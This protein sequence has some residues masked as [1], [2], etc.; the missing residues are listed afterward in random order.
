VSRYV[1]T[2]RFEVE[3]EDREDAMNKVTLLFNIGF[4]TLVADK[5][6]RVQLDKKRGQ[7]KEEMG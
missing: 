4:D 2:A 7:K 6:V 3:G 5:N 1:V